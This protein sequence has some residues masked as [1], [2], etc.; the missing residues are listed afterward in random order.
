MLITIKNAPYTLESTRG[1]DKNDYKCNFY[2]PSRI[3]KIL[4]FSRII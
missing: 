1:M 3:P 4:H 2:R